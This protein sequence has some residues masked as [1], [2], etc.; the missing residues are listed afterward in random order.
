MVVF[1]NTGVI[2]NSPLIIEMQQCPK[3]KKGHHFSPLL[4]SVLANKIIKINK[5]RIFG[6][7]LEV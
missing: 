7:G 3:P 4:H 5:T 1:D 2:P 6:K